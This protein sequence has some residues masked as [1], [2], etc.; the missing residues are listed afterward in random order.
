MQNRN[1][2]P[3][4]LQKYIFSSNSPITNSICHRF[5]FFRPTFYYLNT[6]F[7]IWK[8]SLFLWNRAW[9]WSFSLLIIILRHIFKR[10]FYMLF[11][12]RETRYSDSTRFIQDSATHEGPR[13]AVDGIP[14]DSDILFKITIWWHNFFSFGSPNV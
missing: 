9:I 7:I 5:H 1:L 3:N 13:P 8:K 2:Q 12:D 11:E 14:T 6:L 10:Y 4:Y